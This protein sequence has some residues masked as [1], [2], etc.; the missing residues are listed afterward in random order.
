MKAIYESLTM[1]VAI[2]L[3]T[4][5]SIHDIGVIVGKP[6]DDWLDMVL[7]WFALEA[8]NERLVE[9]KTI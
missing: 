8:R 9:R 5:L 2:P 4:G 7:E 3:S 6:W 1:S